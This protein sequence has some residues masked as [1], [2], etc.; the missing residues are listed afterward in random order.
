MQIVISGCLW[1]VPLEVS[2]AR[3]SFALLEGNLVKGDNALLRESLG[4]GYQRPYT[5]NKK[6]CNRY[7]QSCSD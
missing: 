2:W 4:S 3:Q 6:L 5:A 1:A 7:M